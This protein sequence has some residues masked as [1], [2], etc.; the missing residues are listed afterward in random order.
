[1]KTYSVSEISDGK[2]TCISEDE[3]RIVLPASSLP[4]TLREGD[5]LRFEE[6][7]ATVDNKA[8][9]TKRAQ[10]LAKQKALLR[11]N[12]RRRGK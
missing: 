6:S 1:M 4:P 5:I 10:M 8:T 9:Q 3:S 11:K 7:E 2:V 12:R